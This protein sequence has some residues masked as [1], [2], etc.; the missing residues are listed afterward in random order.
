MFK[1]TKECL[2][3]EKQQS[4]E[5]GQ[6]IGKLIPE[7][8]RISKLDLEK[9][10]NQ[11][12]ANKLLNKTEK[13]PVKKDYKYQEPSDL[14]SIL[15][16]R[17]K[18]PGELKLKLGKSQLYDKIF[19]AW[20][21]RCSGCLL[22]KPVEGWHMERI[23]GY[24]KDSG[25]YPLRKYMSISVPK[26]I[27][28]KYK[29]EHKLWFIENV[30]CMPE[31]D[32]INYTITGLAIIKKHGVE[33]TP[34]D[35]AYF[36]THYIPAG[37]TFSAERVTYRNILNGAEPPESAVIYN[38]YR[39]WIGAQIRADFWGYVMP[40]KM[41]KAAELAFKDASISHIKNGIYGEMWVS[42]MLSSAYV[43]SDIEKVMEYGLSQIPNTS[44]LYEDI[45]QVI[46]WRKDGLSA[47]DVIN[48]IHNKYDEKIPH[49][50]C[51]VISNAMIVAVGLLYGEKDFEKSITLAVSSGFDT[52]C[53][54]ATVGS[55]IGMILGA[56]R[57]P[58]KWIKPL[59]NKI[60]SGIQ[61]YQTIEISKLA[62]LTLEC[63]KK[64]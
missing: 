39:E 10:K 32:D 33:F 41:E 30:D 3:I 15:R 59:N 16:L 24:L 21:G 29:V 4:K 14:K 64:C 35:V 54:G 12:L 6:D 5:E 26:K 37:R 55:I 7:Y 22:G 8:D 19:G 50:W 9:E 27:I 13:L 60:H 63:V 20:L 45:K 44:R 17:N 62:N 1:I 34:K 48:K 49:G 47:E 18:Y 53:N 31:D 11:L 36:W 46:E 40:G 38:P 57:L 23:Q 61:D 56:K 58:K 28:K 25:Q 51:H 52:D 2:L 42:A 43:E